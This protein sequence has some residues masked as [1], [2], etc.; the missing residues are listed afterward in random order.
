MK[1]LVINAGSSSLKY[2]LIDMDSSEV[3]AKGLCE[4][5]GIDGKFSQTAGDREIKMDVAMPSHA[6]AIAQVI[7]AITDSENGCIADLSEITAVGHRV[8]HGAETFKESVLV[9]PETMAGMEELVPF[10][11]LHMPGNL[12]G[13]RACEKAMPGVPQVAVF[14]TSFHQTMDPVA[15]MYALPYKYYE[16]NHIRK[17]GFHGTSHKYITRRTAEMLG[18]SSGEVNL[19]SCHLGNG[20]SICAVQNGKCVDTTM[21]FTPLEGL[22]MGTRSGNLDPAAIFE[23][24]ERENL[25]PAQANDLLNKK[26]GF[27]GL[28]GVSS[29]MRDID[30]AIAE[31]NTRAKLARDMLV[32]QV[33]KYI[34]SYLAV[35][36]RVDAITFTAGV[37]ENGIELRR[38]I[39]SGLEHLGIELDEKRNDTRRCEAL[40]SKDSSKVKLFVIPT[41]EELMIARDTREIV[42]AL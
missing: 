27:L 4:R 8:L 19:I 25:T 37:G 35:L 38:D 21:G 9:T 40:I 33:K 1:I 42:E 41:N 12:M 31:G 18:K 7:S 28:S 30:A 5:I 15:F 14:D 39:V 26:S 13:I 36:G 20:S 24:M 3:M 34:G 10:G 32:Y 2:Q 23:I 6:E 11:P 22:I 29:D 16:E 17:Y